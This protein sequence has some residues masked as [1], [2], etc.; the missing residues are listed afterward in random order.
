MASSQEGMP[1][2]TP[3]P[4]DPAINPENTLLPETMQPAFLLTSPLQGTPGQDDE[5]TPHCALASPCITV[6]T[7]HSLLS[8]QLQIFTH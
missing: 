7:L 4:Q 1:I 8:A 6:H 3:P 2:L 5:S